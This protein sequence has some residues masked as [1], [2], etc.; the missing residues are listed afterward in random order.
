M[1]ACDMRHVACC[2]LLPVALARFRFRLGVKSDAHA[3]SLSPSLFF[4]FLF[5]KT[6]NK[7]T[8]LNQLCQHFTAL[9]PIIIHQEERVIKVRYIASFSKRC[10]RS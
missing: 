3:F 9:Q 4:R 10:A 8:L 5:L 1:L 2:M 6:A 7:T